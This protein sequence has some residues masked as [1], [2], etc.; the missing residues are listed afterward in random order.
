MVQCI[1]QP[2]QCIIEVLIRPSC[3]QSGHEDRQHLHSITDATGVDSFPLILGYI[4]L[5]KWHLW[6]RGRSKCH[7]QALVVHA[8][9]MK[10]FE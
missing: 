1:S 10:F 5:M 2:L 8:D 3:A 6:D 7:G 4:V 9:M